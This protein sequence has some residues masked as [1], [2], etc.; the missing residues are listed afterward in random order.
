MRVGYAKEHASGTYI[1]LKHDN[2][3]YVMSW[4]IT[5]DEPRRKRKLTIEATKDPS[6]TV[7]SPQRGQTIENI[8]HFA[9]L[10][11]DSEN[12]D[13]DNGG[14]GGNVAPVQQPGG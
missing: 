6:G 4:D 9:A 10:I 12:S 8:N 3:K 13:D 5:W 14:D 7:I 1:V 11:S 2:N